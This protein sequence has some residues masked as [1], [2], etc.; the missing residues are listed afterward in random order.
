MQLS[1]KIHFRPCHPIEQES[2]KTLLWAL[3][4]PLHI[5]ERET[6]DIVLRNLWTYGG[7][8]GIY[9]GADLIGMFGY[10]LGEPKQEFFNRHISF[11]YVAGILPAH[12]RPG[13]F[14]RG[15]YALTQHLD[16]LGV[17]EMR[18][19]AAED[20]P[21]TQRLYGRLGDEIGRE[22]NGRG[23]PCILYA[24]S[25]DLVLARTNRQTRHK[26]KALN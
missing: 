11:I 14:L 8:L 20:D 10:F 13:I 26:I 6:I 16:E 9:E 17:S 21:Y 15:V 19:H 22:L 4:E 23:L 7:V 25:V 3:R 5:K 12:Q 2:L 1:K 24:C 18:C